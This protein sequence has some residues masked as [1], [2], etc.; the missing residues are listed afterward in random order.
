MK[1]LLDANII[2]E[3]MKQQPDYRVLKRLELDGI[4]SCTSATVWHELWHGVNLLKK[5]P[6]K[7]SIATYLD[8]LVEENFTILPFCQLA[9]E[10]LAEER[11]RLKGQG[12]IPAKYDSEI[13]AVAYVNQLTVVTRNER[14]FSCFTNVRVDNWFE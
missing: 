2:S 4:F 7:K 3:V 8:L 10:W 12:I 9:A 5:S 1:Y 6:R 11:V 14:D 13:A